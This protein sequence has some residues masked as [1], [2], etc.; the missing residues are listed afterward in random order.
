MAV[1]P[2]PKRSTRYRRRGQHAA[3][4]AAGYR[5]ASPRHRLRRW[6]GIASLLDKLH[7]ALAVIDQGVADQLLALAIEIANQVLRQ[8]LRV[9]PELLLSVVREA[10]STL[11]PHHGQPLL[12]VHPDDAALVRK[13]LGEQLSHMPLANHRRQH[14]DGWRLSSRTGCQRSRRDPGDALAARHRGHRRQPGMAP[15]PASDQDDRSPG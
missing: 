15:Q 9:Q 13:H 3:G 11:H 10:L 8:S 7:Q 4:H 14:A 2:A 1:C 5:K 6:P 12:F